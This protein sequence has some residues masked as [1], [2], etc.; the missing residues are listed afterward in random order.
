MCSIFIYCKNLYCNSCDAKL[1]FHHHYSSLQCHMIF[2]NHPNMLICCSIKI[3]NYYHCWKLLC[4]LIFLWKPW[5]MIQDSLM[6]RKFKRTAFI[7]NRNLATLLMSLLSLLI[8][9][10][11]SYSIKVLTPPPPP[12]PYFFTDAILTAQE[13]WSSHICSLIMIIEYVHMSQSGI[14]LH[15]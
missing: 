13:E 8:N 2:R 15:F 14:I 4:C 3:S 10:V 5:Y 12:P 1:N 7:W 11:H 6:N 9:L